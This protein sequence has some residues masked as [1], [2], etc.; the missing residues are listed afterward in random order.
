MLHLTAYYE[1]VDQAGNDQEIAAVNDG[2]LFTTGDE[3]RVDAAIPN[4][5]GAGAATAAG[6][7]DS[8][9]VRSPSLRV[10]NNF[11]ISPINNGATWQSPAEYPLLFDT[12]ISLNATE[13]VTLSTDSDNASAVAI[14]G[15]VLYGSGPIVKVQNEI[16]SAVCTTAI[17]ASASD[18][19]FGPVTFTQSLPGGRYNVVGLRSFATGLVLSRLR[20]PGQSFFPGF[21]AW[22]DNKTQGDLRTRFGNCGVLG[23]FD[24]DSPFSVEIIGGSSTSQTHIVDLVKIA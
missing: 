15:F 17:T 22:I 24:N 23:S 11:P 5:L 9:T 12:P 2:V 19:N 8:G 6:T 16:F 7:F 4:L 18:W 1:S 13:P 21:P 20:F 10:R 14:Y 3:I